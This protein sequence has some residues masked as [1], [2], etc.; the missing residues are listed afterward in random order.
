MRPI[1]S[2]AKAGALKAIAPYG[3]DLNLPSGQEKRARN[4]RVRLLDPLKLSRYCCSTYGTGRVNLGR[5]RNDIRETYD[6][7]RLQRLTN[8]TVSS[9]LYN[10]AAFNHSQQLDYDALGNITHK[11]DVGHYTYAENGAG[12][13]A[14]TSIA[15]SPGQPD[16]SFDYDANGNMQSDAE[17]T[18]V[19][20]SD[21]RKLSFFIYGDR[22]ETTISPEEW[23]EIH[24]KALSFYKSEIV[25]MKTLLSITNKPHVTFYPEHGEIKRSEGKRERKLSS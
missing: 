1:D 20:I 10:I 17:R 19:W 18:M 2:P 13:H 12:V 22:A 25:K 5:C 3:A 7:D 21:D 14:L 23:I 6:Y 24:E 16:N 4:Q 11:S 8:T 9:G 15:G